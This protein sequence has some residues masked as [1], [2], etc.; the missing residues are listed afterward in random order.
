MTITPNLNTVVS[1]VP[2]LKNQQDIE[3]VIK[4]IE[5]LQEA[6]SGYEGIEWLAPSPDETPRE[7]VENVSCS[8]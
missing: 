3:A 8:L 1:D 6:L 4:G 5:N 2:Y 7:F